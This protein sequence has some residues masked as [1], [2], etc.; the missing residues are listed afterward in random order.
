MFKH[1]IQLFQA[2]VCKLSRKYTS[3]TSDNSDKVNYRPQ[4][5]MFKNSLSTTITIFQFYVSY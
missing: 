2:I 3:H 4:E 1:F 5:L